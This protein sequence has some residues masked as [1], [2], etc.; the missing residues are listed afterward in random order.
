MT[1]F[2]PQL[3]HRCRHP[4]CRSK[5]PTPVS[6][7][8]RAFCTPGCHSSF[9]LKRCLV[10]ENEKPAK[11]TARR[12][13]CR[14]PKC[15]S[16][17]RQNS[18]HYAFSGRDTISA[19][20]ALRSA[21]KSHVSDG[22]KWAVAGGPAL[23]PNQLHCATVADGPDCQWRGGEY[24]RIETKNR[25]ALKT[26]DD[27]FTEPDWREVISPDGVRCWVTRGRPHSTGAPSD[28]QPCAPDIPIADDL[29]IP[30]FLRR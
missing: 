10:C 7:P 15:E 28:W 4:K 19:A 25:A 5:L 14:R 22:P 23:T 2:A 21:H 6:N 30:D 20:N 24:E 3:R 16:R 29:S 26:V 9:Y 17:Y 13:L 1:D 11:S 8:H 18:R 12:K 27:C